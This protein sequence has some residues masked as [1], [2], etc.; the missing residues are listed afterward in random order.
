MATIADD[1]CNRWF[2]GNSIAQCNRTSLTETS[3]KYSFVGI[4][5]P[6]C[7]PVIDLFLD[8]LVEDPP[9]VLNLFYIK[10]LLVG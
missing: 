6:S 1:P 2:T 5:L 10:Y 8:T 4:R 3:H 7:L 9:A